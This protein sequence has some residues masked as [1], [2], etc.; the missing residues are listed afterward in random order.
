MAVENV[1]SGSSQVPEYL[2]LGKG[3]GLKRSDFDS[4]LEYT[5]ESQAISGDQIG[6]AL[7]GDYHNGP[8]S[9]VIP[10]GIWGSIAFVWFV[11][12]GFRVLLN[13]YRYGS[14]GLQIINAF[15]LADFIT[16]AFMFFVVVGGLTT[17]MLHFTGLWD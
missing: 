1:E 15:L 6:A 3:L 11:V 14:P 17:D 4:T 16:R 10:F 12:A 7:A 8:L 9:V 2:L 5:F 13:N